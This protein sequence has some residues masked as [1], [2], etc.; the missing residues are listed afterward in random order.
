MAGAKLRTYLIVG[1]WLA[2][3]MLLWVVLSEVSGGIL[4]ISHRTAA[5]IILSLST[6]K[7][8]LVAMYYMHLKQDRP[9]LIGIALAP[10]VLLT[11]A[12]SV[13]F[14]SFLIHF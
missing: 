7:A 8:L 13:V 9:L 3:L 5:I 14:S 1:M 12:L 4:P 10:F 6:I 2:G 11:L